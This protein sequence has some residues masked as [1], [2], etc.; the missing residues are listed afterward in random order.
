MVA[1]LSCEQL[2]QWMDQ[3]VD[4]I[5]V[6]VRTDEERAF[7]CIEPSI[8]LTSAEDVETLL[9]QPD[10]RPVVFYCHHGIRSFSAASWFVQRGLK[11][12]YNLTGGIDTWSQRIDPNIPVY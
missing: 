10:G 12:A 11:R 7:A 6:D 1:E 8:H 2:K 3:Q 5:L 4:H 9:N